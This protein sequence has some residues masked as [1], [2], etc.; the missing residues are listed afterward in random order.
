MRAASRAAALLIGVPLAVGALDF[1]MKA[2]D[3]S[4]VSIARFASENATAVVAS[5]QSGGRVLPIFTTPRVREQFL[6]AAPPTTFT[7]DSVKEEFFRTQVP[8]GSIIY[9]EAKRNNLPPEL[10][11]AVIQTE[12][13]FR[14][15]LVSH[16]S[17]QGLMQIVPSTARIL[18]VADPFSPDQNIAAGTK[19]LKYLLERFE[20][21]NVALAAY[22]AGEGNVERF[23]GIPPFAETRGYLQK[24]S[25]R[26]FHYRQCVR[27]TYI[28]SARLR[29]ATLH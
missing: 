20:D 25:A 3:V 1:P 17:A 5:A 6:P 16:K 26:T 10:V 14:P 22:N 11:A 27:N 15:R 12:S 8:Y 13:D 24:V 19:Y 9:R 23:G 2:M 7:V 29:R 21:Q 18:G 28:A 4:V